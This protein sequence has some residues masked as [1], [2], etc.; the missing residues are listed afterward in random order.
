M[1][2]GWPRGGGVSLMTSRAEEPSYFE[3]HC[4]HYLVLMIDVYHIILG[5]TIG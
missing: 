5:I 1:G 3:G 4:P 2:G